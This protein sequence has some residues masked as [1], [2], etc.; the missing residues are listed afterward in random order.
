MSY[1]H[2][3]L[4]IGNISNEVVRL[5]ALKNS[6]FYVMRP[7]LQK[8]Y[9]VDSF[10]FAD[11]GCSLSMGAAVVCLVGDYVNTTFLD[12][13]EFKDL[14]DAYVDG[15]AVIK[16]DLVDRI[17]IE[18]LTKEQ[19]EATYMKIEDTE[20]VPGLI[21]CAIAECLNKNAI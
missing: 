8:V 2:T 5:H 13:K 6:S 15:Y 4:P 11:I 21:L 3:D 7:R 16:R 12:A 10:E 18:F 1:F 14:A 19:F 20:N 9:K 17:F